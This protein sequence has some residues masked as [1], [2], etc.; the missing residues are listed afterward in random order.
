MKAK[1]ETRLKRLEEQAGTRA[2]YRH[3][4]TMTDA[5]LLAIIKA[6]DAGM[7]A[8]REEMLAGWLAEPLADAAW[9]ADAL[10]YW[11]EWN[12]SEEAAAEAK[13]ASQTDETDKQEVAE[14]R[15]FLQWG[16]GLP[17]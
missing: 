12:A 15:A 6:S 14:F 4:S 16:K 11:E 1:L 2:A 3:V 7:R 10:E 17:V 9:K 13:A 8:W 5:E